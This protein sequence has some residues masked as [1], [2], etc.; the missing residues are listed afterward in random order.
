MYDTT[1][2]EGQALQDVDY[3]FTAEAGLDRTHYTMTGN[4]NG[5]GDVTVDVRVWYQS[6]PAR[7]VAPMFDIQDSTIQAFQSLFEAQGAAPEL[8]AQTSVTIPVTTGLGGQPTAS[9]LRV[10]PN[11]APEGEVQVHAPEDALGGLYEVY[12][13]DGSRVQHGKV[14]SRQWTLTLPPA[15][16]T[17]VLRVYGE[18]E[19]WTR[20]MV[21]R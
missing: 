13:P 5:A 12:A 3:A 10:H 1:R 6:M 18:R 2:I 21:R 15:S 7:W 9:K 4:P 8:V 17:Y 20:R 14:T 19:V 11:P 16:G